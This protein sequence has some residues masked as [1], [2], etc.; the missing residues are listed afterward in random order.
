MKCRFYL[1]TTNNMTQE[2]AEYVPLLN[3]D[4]YVIMNQ[5][6]FTIRKKGNYKK[7]KDGFHKST[8]YIRVYLEN[9]HSY[10]KH[11]LIAQQFIPNPDN[12]PSVDHINHDRTDNHLENLR[13]VSNSENQRNK[14]S[15]MGITY[16][17]VDNIPDDSIVVNDYGDHEF[18]NY[19]YYNDVFYFYNGVQYRKLHINEFK[20]GSKFVYMIDTDGKCVSVCYN[21]FKKIYNFD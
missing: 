10:Q 11:R 21:K 20:N 16:D 3:H 1:N 7:V 6:P 19:Y 14:S 13:W 4:D 18:E 9:N 17:Y 15:H 2:I 5:Y 8:G 12:L